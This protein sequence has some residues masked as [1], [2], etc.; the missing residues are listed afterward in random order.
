M[1]QSYLVFLFFST[2][3]DS[4]I[5]DTKPTVS[6]CSCVLPLWKHPSPCVPLAIL[7]SSFQ[8]KHFALGL[9][10]GCLVKR[11]QGSHATSLAV[12][13]TRTYLSSYTSQ[14]EVGLST[15]TGTPGQHWL[16]S[17]LLLQVLGW[18]LGLE[19]HQSFNLVM[20][21]VHVLN[22]CRLCKHHLLT[23]AH[24]VQLPDLA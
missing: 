15:D 23:P 1:A 22:S 12:T 14:T 13:D 9:G 17:P 24:S 19:R 20:R 5:P 16:A 21:T 4:L 18:T 2:Q 7:S 10:R 11:K 3:L 8:P 6:L